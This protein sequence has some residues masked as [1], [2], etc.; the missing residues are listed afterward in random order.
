MSKK[1][2]LLSVALIVGCSVF[3]D[4]TTTMIRKYPSVR[5]TTSAIQSSSILYTNAGRTYEEDALQPAIK[6]LQAKIKQNPNDY[7]L[8]TSIIEL[9]IKSGQNNKAFEELIFLNNLAKQNKLDSDILARLNSIY[10]NHK[11]GLRYDRNR[12]PLYVNL[13]MLALIQKENIKAEEYINAAA[14]SNQAKEMLESAI[15]I[16][17]DTTKNT[18]KAIAVCDK[19]IAKNP[20]NIDIRKQKA[21]YLA[22]L[23]DK[24]GA[25]IEYQKILQVKPSDNESKY[26]LYKALAAKGMQEKDII[27]QICN[28]EKPDY[29]S[30][31]YDIADMLLKNG[32]TS[33]AKRFAEILVNKYPDNANG[34]ILLSEIYKKEGKLKESYDALSKVRDKADSNEAIAKYNVMLAKLSDQPVQEANSLI[35]T[36]LYQQALEVL[37]SADQDALYVIL[38]QVRANYLL[39]KKSNSFDLLNKAMNLYPE[40]SDVYCAFGYIYLQEKDIDTARKYT[41]KSLKINPQ[42]RTAMDLLDMVNQAETDKMMNS[43]VSSYES[44]NYAETMRILDEA[45]KINTKDPNLY[46]YKALTYIA[47]NNYAASTASLY[48]CIELDRNN[49]QAYFYLATAFDNLS[50]HQNALQNYQKYINLLSNDDYGES[51]RRTYALTRIKKLSGK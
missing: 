24:D 8:Y 15:P 22:Q 17:F 33:S 26:Y 25:I 13:A 44:Q 42:N 12:Y 37:D 11:A 40:N 14:E 41:N 39:N 32:E 31:Y 43:I 4:T 38:T 7:T 19:I 34:Y 10:L 35:A 51:E 47:Q 6:E 45:L 2:Y 27:K 21:A 36:G 29:E 50:E 28:S 5:N 23:G 20:G 9:Y 3:A 1:I 48:K 46:L 30:A 49:K 16:V 18:Q